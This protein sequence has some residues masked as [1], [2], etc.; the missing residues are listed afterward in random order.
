[1]TL[2]ARSLLRLALAACDRGDAHA[3]GVLVREAMAAEPDEPS[4]VRPDAESYAT[5]GRRVG[6][7][8]RTVR[9]MV[10][11]GRIPRAAVVGIGSGRRVLVTEALASLRR[12]G[13]TSS[14]EADGASYIARRGSL[15]LASGGRP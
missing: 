9:A 6:A 2:S 3:A 13:P 15:R 4:G 7:S 1:M 10:A 5:F 14:A 12:S 11:D 8:A